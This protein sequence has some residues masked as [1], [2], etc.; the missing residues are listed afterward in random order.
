MDCLHYYLKKIVITPITHMWET[1][2][3]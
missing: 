2:C 3:K 1:L